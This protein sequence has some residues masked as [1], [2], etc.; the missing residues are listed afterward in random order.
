MSQD[1]VV[2]EYYV[3]AVR[4]STSPMTFA[5][6]MGRAPIP[7]YEEDQE[8]GLVLQTVISMSPQH[9]K[10]FSG[11]LSTLVERYESENGPLINVEIEV[12]KVQPNEPAAE[13]SESE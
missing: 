6:L 13:T 10:I 11:L 9:A 1:R 3:D 8:S 4:I 7:E 5:F 12:N 2:T